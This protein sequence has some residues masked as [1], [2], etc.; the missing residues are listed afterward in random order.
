MVNKKQDFASRKPELVSYIDQEDDW[1]KHGN[2]RNSIVQ[3]GTVDSNMHTTVVLIIL[4]P[5][6]GNTDYAIASH[7]FER[8]I[9][10]NTVKGFGDIQIAC[11]YSSTIVQRLSS[12]IRCD[13]EFGQA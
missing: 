4:Q 9:I 5:H 3:E 12:A 8:Y 2:L 11:V 13:E 10:I 1:I 6:E 7:P